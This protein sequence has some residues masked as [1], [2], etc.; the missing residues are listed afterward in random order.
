MSSPKAVY[1]MRICSLQLRCLKN[2]ERILSPSVTMQRTVRS[3]CERM[4][5]IS[6]FHFLSRVSA[7]LQHPMGCDMQ[8]AL[9]TYYCG[10]AHS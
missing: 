7:R 1:E 4:A 8:D 10:N 6:L 3:A 9:E 2:L 5:R